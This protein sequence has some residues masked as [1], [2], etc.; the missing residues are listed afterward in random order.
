MVEDV[1]TAALE[2]DLLGFKF[3]EELEEHL[4]LLAANPEEVFNVDA[5]TGAADSGATLPVIGTETWS[6]WLGLDWL[7]KNQEKVVY[8]AGRKKF[9]FG[10]GKL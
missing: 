10:D 9:K 2:D 3:R 7:Q 5:G 6:K 1:C 4:N 8:R